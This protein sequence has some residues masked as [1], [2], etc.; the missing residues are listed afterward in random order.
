MSSINQDRRKNK[1]RRVQAKRKIL[2]TLVFE[3]EHNDGIETSQS[4]V[5]S[6]TVNRRTEIRIATAT[7][8]TIDAQ[9]AIWNSLSHSSKPGFTSAA[10][11]ND[12]LAVTVMKARKLRVP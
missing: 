1:L 9:A 6:L 5:Y 3:V 2:K 10:K 12:F 8:R 7:I 4:S 11:K